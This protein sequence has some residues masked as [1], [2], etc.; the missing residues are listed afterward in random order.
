MR[1]RTPHTRIR[2]E[3][4]GHSGPAARGG[5]GSL[6]S[7]CIYRAF[8]ILGRR[9]ASP[10]RKSRGAEATFFGRAGGPAGCGAKNHGLLEYSIHTPWNRHEV[11]SPGLAG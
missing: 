11:H 1:P 4:F 9:K 3:M 7:H 2:I 10:G 5:E 6:A 8:I